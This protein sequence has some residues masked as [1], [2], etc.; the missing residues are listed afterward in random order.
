ME[1]RR[2]GR[3]ED[4]SSIM[5]RLTIKQCSVGHL[6]GIALGFLVILDVICAQ[7]V[8]ALFDKPGGLV[9]DQQTA[10]T[11]AEA[12]LFPIYSE[13]SIRDQRPYEIKLDEGKW[14]INGTLRHAKDPQD[15]VVGG[16]FHIVISQRDARVIEIGHGT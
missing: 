2:S 10:I 11:I 15:G 14:I 5:T 7:N 16:T 1:Y 3:P 9:P 8:P 6:A 4:R 12:I 13:K